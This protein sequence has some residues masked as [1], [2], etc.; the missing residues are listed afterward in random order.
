LVPQNEV[1]HCIWW[2][3]ALMCLSV[4]GLMLSAYLSWHHIVGGVVLG[5]GGGSPCEEVLN[6]RW[7]AIGGLVPVS[8]LAMGVYLAMLVASFFTGPANAAP[9]RQLA[10]RAML[11][12]VGAA[13]GSAVWFIIV[14]KWL[15]GAFCPYCT[16]THITSLL[17]AVLV[18]W[19]APRQFDENSQRVVAPRFAAG[20]AMAGLA[21]AG[22]LVVF[23][24]RIKPPAVYRGG[25]WQRTVPAI[26][27]HSAPLAGSPNAPYVLTVL[28][29]YK[30]PHCQQLHF[31]LDEAVRR[32]GG[33][34]AFVLC[35]SPLNSQCN[36]YIPRDVDEFKGSCE[37]ARVALAVWVARREMF[38]IF[39]R[40]MF[41][42]E[43]GDRWQ[44]RSLDSARAK[45]IELVGRAKFDAA[46]ADPWISQYLQTS[47]RIYG[48]TIQN[49]NNAVPKLVYGSRWVI[50]APNDAEDLV[51][52][53]NNSLA[54]PKP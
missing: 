25:D 37:L 50:P 51:S 54:L 24:A 42:I 7:S 47:V 15:V 53:L 6:S 2:R 14:Q 23:Q 19:Q 45:A 1:S 22:M 34:L 3:W 32:Y 43:S 4:L 31:I 33:K 17:L 5:C 36:P 11:V 27:P 38:P 26:D 35:P 30:C 8:G 39:N 52:I 18:I 49:G 48:S 16:A 41:S 13:G 29:D 9:V 40:W 12:F 28:F 46:L 10:W 21:L 20:L 44:P